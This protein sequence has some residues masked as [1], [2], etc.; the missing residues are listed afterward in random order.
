[1]P[2]HKVASTPG[3]TEIDARER[4]NLRGTADMVRRPQ[5][6]QLVRHALPL[7]FWGTGQQNGATPRKEP[8]R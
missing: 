2:P 7:P 5:A 4:R 1:M 8:P 3:S 6:G